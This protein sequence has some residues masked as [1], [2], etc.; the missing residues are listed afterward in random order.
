MPSLEPAVH[1]W[2]GVSYRGH[3]V[4]DYFATRFEQK[5]AAPHRDDV[6]RHLKR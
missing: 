5:S 1:D 6:N 2:S 3:K 4:S